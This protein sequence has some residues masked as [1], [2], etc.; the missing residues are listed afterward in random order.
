MRCAPP[1]MARPF[2]GAPALLARLVTLASPALRFL[3][4][5]ATRGTGASSHGGPDVSSVEAL[6]LEGAQ[7]GLRYPLLPHA[8]PAP[9]TQRPV[10]PA[11][12]GRRLPRRLAGA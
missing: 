8:H 4:D 7:G 11:G 9:R 2:A 5:G 1:R 3:A 10:P 12:T 6:H